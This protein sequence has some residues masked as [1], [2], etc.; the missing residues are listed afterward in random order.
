M[1]GLLQTLSDSQR[2]A[3][4]ESLGRV[5]SILSTV[6]IRANGS[7]ADDARLLLNEYYREA[8]VIQKDTP[9]SVQ[10]FL[11]RTDSGFWIAY[12][13]GAPAGCVVL[14]PL[15]KFRSA[16]ECKRLYVR[17]QFRRRGIAEALLDVMEDYARS[18]SLSWIY[19]DSKDDLQ[20]AIAL[21]RRRGYE[22]CERY[23]ENVQATVFLRKSLPRP[24]AP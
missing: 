22:P 20:A 15:E 10:W 2:M 4:V 9:E 12:V 8:G 19:L 18:S 7:H 16:G 23:N 13:E 21:Y 17:A 24:P 11:T 14:R 6:V 3:L 5:P 1:K